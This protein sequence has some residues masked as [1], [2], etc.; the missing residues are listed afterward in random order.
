VELDGENPHI[1]GLQKKPNRVLAASGPW[2][3]SG[4]WWNGS[5]WSR[6]EWDIALQTTEGVGLYRLYRDRIQK[7]WFVEGIFD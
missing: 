2:C 7:R 6:E 5:R 1:V 4:D 3:S